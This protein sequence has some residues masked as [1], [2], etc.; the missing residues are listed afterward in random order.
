[1]AID[2]QREECLSLSQAAKILPK[3][4]GTKPPHPMTLY[5]WAKQGLKMPDGSRVRLETIWIG[6]TQVTSK[7]ALIRFFARRANPRLPE[8]AKS[9]ADLA[10][11]LL[12]TKQTG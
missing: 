3:L 11:E 5:R 4:R 7:E 12:R 6:G 8:S 9:Q 1:M 10:R 2:M